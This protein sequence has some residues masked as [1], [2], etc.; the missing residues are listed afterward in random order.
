MG[1]AYAGLHVLIPKSVREYRQA[2]RLKEDDSDMF[3]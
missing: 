3:L 2:T 1:Q